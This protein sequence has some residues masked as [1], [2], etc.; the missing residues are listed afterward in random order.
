MQLVTKM[1]C[2]F[3]TFGQPKVGDGSWNWGRPKVVTVVTQNLALVSR[4]DGAI[5]CSLLPPGP[6]K[7]QWVFSAPTQN[8]L[9]ALG[10]SNRIF[11]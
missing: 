6:N 1:E 2:T 10:L 5:G 4:I 11:V 3:R 8:V 9:E 7:P